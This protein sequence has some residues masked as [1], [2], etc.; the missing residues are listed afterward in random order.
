[1]Y[2]DS[3]DDPFEILKKYNLLAHCT[4]PWVLVDCRY[5]TEDHCT[6]CSFCF[7]LLSNAFP[8]LQSADALLNRKQ[9]E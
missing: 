6:P 5:K 8:S 1:M 4:V 9:V 7:F 3:L 2:D